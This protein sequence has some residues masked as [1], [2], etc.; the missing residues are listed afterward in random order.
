MM[1]ER[2]EL[3]THAWPELRRRCLERLVELVEADLPGG[4]AEGQSILKETLKLP[5]HPALTKQSGAQ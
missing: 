5:G 4:T 1:R 3:M 2:D